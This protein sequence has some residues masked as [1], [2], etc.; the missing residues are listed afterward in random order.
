LK[1]ISDP[2]GNFEPLWKNLLEHVHIESYSADMETRLRGTGDY[3]KVS[4]VDW[5]IEEYLNYQTEI[6][7]IAIF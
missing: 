1:G 6:I 3:F 2:W 4:P 7:D 5:A